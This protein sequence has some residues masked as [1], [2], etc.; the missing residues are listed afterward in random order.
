MGVL[1]TVA[2]FVFGM[3]CLACGNSSE[4][5]DPWLCPACAAERAGFLAGNGNLP[6]K[7][8]DGAESV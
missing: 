3:E 8:P 4:R 5:L 2:N 7:T 1:R 6:G